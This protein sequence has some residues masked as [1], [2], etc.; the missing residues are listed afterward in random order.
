MQFVLTCVDKPGSGQIRLNNRPAHL[1]YLKGPGDKLIMAGPMLSDDGESPVGSVLVVDVE[2]RAAAQALADG[3]P[4]ARAG[5]FEAV[6]IRRFRTVI[7]AQ[8]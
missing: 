4:Y 6:M 7:P 8:G 2:D 5:L 3:D 1:D